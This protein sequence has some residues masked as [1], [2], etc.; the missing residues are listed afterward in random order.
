MEKKEASNLF[1]HRLQTLQRAIGIYSLCHA[2]AAALLKGLGTRLSTPASYPDL[3]TRWAAS[4]RRRSIPRATVSNVILRFE[5]LE[6]AR[7]YPAK[8]ADSKAILW[9][10]VLHGRRDVAN[11]YRLKQRGL[12]GS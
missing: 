11:Y 10:D 3:R 6:T 4:G 2:T 1:K 12:G 7:V 9:T 8:T 5:D